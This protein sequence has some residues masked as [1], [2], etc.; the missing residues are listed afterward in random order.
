[1]EEAYAIAPSGIIG[2][3]HFARIMMEKGYVS[4]V[5][6]GFDKWLGVG[7]PAYDG[8]QA[9]TAQEAV[10]L[11]KDIGGHAFVA[12]PHL[13]RISDEALRAFLIELKAYGLDGIEGYYN[14]Y[15]SE[16]QD[17]FQSMA[18]ELG[19]KIS[20]GTDFHA[21]MKPHIEI[22]IGQGN[23]KIPYSVLENIRRV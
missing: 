16:M 18:K 13:I 11:I 3:A 7:K 6:E 22:G 20:G 17:K 4:S 21:K 23:M 14:E 9:L 15:T 8:T 19:L 5:K 12:H 1:M 10:K 2:R